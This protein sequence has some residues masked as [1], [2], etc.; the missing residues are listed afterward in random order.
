M[1]DEALRY[2]I[3]EADAVRAFGNRE[4]MTRD[5]AESFLAELL[6]EGGGYTVDN[7]VL[8]KGRDLQLRTTV[9]VT[10]DG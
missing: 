5:A 8:I 10:F 2:Y 4:G 1:K 7:L 3:I 9:G 6:D